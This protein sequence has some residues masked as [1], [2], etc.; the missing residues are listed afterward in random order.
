MFV[1]VIQAHYGVIYVTFS[2]APYKIIEILLN[3]FIW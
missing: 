1:K 3:S 2:T